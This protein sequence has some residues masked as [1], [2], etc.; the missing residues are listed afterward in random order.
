MTEIMFIAAFAL[1]TLALLY[2]IVLLHQT[3]NQLERTLETYRNDNARRI[4]KTTQ[5]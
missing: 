2:W 3:I 4:R 5:L 1:L